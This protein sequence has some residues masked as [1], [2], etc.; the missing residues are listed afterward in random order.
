MPIILV[1]A[2]VVGWRAESFATEP[3]GPCDV[4]LS[5]FQP[6]FDAEVTL[7]GSSLTV[8]YRGVE[9]SVKP[10]EFR[11]LRIVLAAPNEFIRLDALKQE[12]WG[13]RPPP[14]SGE[15]FNR[16]VGRLRAKLVRV[17][18]GFDK[19]R[20]Q[21]RDSIYWA[22]AEHARMTL[23][24]VGVANHIYEGYGRRAPGFAESVRARYA[25]GLVQKRVR[26]RGDG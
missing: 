11:L 1:M 19:L 3:T 23:G 21:L 8:T 20:V 9:F 4:H 22:R 2:L 10:E 26:H 17:D 24:R 14:K 5:D 25:S 15:V 13:T 12:L 6:S 16:L 18:P 7:D